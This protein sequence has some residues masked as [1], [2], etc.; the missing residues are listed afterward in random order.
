MMLPFSFSKGAA[1]FTVIG[2][3]LATDEGLPE[4][5]GQTY[6]L[7]AG[8]FFTLRDGRVARISNYYNQCYLSWRQHR[9]NS[10]YCYRR[11]NPIHVFMDR[12][13]NQCYSYR[14][15]SRKL[16]LDSA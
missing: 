12:R 5:N 11:F 1:E 13:F 3:Y 14:I 9:S 7:P 6:M 4:A 10:I 15:N 2:E 16:Y 8:A